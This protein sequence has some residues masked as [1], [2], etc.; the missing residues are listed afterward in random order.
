MKDTA[1]FRGK[2]VGS[3]IRPIRKVSIAEEIAKQIMDLISSG[4]L[5]PG[6]RLPSERELCEHFGASRPPLREALRGLSIVGVLNARVGEG[7][8]VSVDGGM[9]M[10]KV[11]ELRMVTEK[12]DIENLLEVRLAL[13]VM[14][15]ARAARNATEEDLN[16]LRELV[17]K[18]KAC[19][20]NE[21]QFARLDAE[22]HVVIAKASG[23]TLILDLV[24]MIRNQ[25]IRA[26]TKALRSPN[27]IS[28][29]NK[30][31]STLLDAIERHDID[32]SRAAMLAHL[33][34][35]QRHSM[36]TEGRVESNAGRKTASPG[37]RPRARTRSSQ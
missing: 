20:T 30:E 24:S 6:Q 3:K 15:A 8:S 32:A 26:L 37:K 23:N 1:R 33:E 18:M 21:T 28:H 22:F 25:L 14:S 17:A 19:G 5:R 10:R 11:M 35:F 4:S 13:E 36:D 7:T 27:A 34:G 9:F 16:E 29:S 31:H 12:H 2:S